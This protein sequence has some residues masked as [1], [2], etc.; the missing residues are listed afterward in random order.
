MSDF[1]VPARHIDYTSAGLKLLKE[2]PFDICIEN[3]LSTNQAA[4]HIEYIALSVPIVAAAL[5]CCN[6]IAFRA[7]A[8]PPTDDTGDETCLPNG[9]RI[10]HEMYG[11]VLD[12]ENCLSAHH[13]RIVFSFAGFPGGS[14]AIPGGSGCE[15]Y[16]YPSTTNQWYGTLSLRG[17][18]L[19]LA[20]SCLPGGPPDFIPT[21]RLSWIGCDEGCVDVLPQCIDPLIINFGNITLPSCCDCIESQTTTTGTINIWVVANCY[22][23]VWARHIGF[24]D[25]KP[26]VAKRNKCYYSGEVPETCSIM[27]CGLVAT[28]TAIDS[29]CACLNGTVALPYVLTQWYYL[30]TGCGQPLT[31]RMRCED[32]GAGSG[33]WPG[34]GWVTL[35]FDIICGADT[36]GTGY[37]FVR[38]RDM[39]NLDV[40][41][42]IYVSGSASAPCGECTWQWNEMP[43]SWSQL[44]FCDGGCSCAPP[45]FSGT[46]DRQTTTT[47]C[48]MGDTACCNGW[49]SVRVMR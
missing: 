7:N 13:G 36:T 44:T 26:L 9:K 4:R 25:G 17:G 14:Q 28:I 41:F 42:L 43:M 18:D 32:G 20:V 45:D 10:P 11:H 21:F 19:L 38:A 49:V 40:E 5:D 46:V 1:V 29:D 30:G 16:G 23:V 24:L 39:E 3:G 27:T 31:L 15:P 35:I 47:P 34:T 8:D 2:L 6:D 12:V 22:D 37:A 33:S 48:S